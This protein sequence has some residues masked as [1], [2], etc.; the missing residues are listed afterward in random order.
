VDIAPN[1]RLLQNFSL[2]SF[3]INKLLRRNSMRLHHLRAALLV[4]ATAACT[5]SGSAIPGPGA[6]GSAG[7]GVQPGGSLPVLWRDPGAIGGKDLFW[8]P[9]AQD[10]APRPPFQ[11]V[12]EPDRGTR[13]KIEVT[14]ARG[15][16]WTIKFPG[17]QATNEVHA[18]IAASRIVWALG[19]FAEEHH[20]VPSGRIEGIPGSLERA[21][22]DVKA[23]GTF[24]VARF[25][26]QEENTQEVGRWAFDRNPFVGTRELSGLVILLTMLNSWDHDGDRNQAILRVRRPDGAPEDRYLI[27]DLGSTFGKMA[28][29]GDQWTRWNLADYE[30]QPFVDGVGKS[31][32]D[33][34]YVG[35][36]PVE[37]KVPLDHAAWFARLISQLSSEQVRRAFEAAGATEAEARGFTARLM[38]KISELRKA[39]GLSARS[40]QAS[41]WLG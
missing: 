2:D 23:D 8:G 10:R 32:I 34:H 35:R 27:S 4:S 38:G 9:T 5:S 30:A 16:R 17:S 26:R 3:Y 7:S 39:T 14:D 41:T 21:E 12:A 13:P 20:Y 19:Y 18:E 6:P 37:D 24:A 33:L 29:H 28:P 36:G 1:P 11:F 22:S 15:V 40:S 25:E 31:T